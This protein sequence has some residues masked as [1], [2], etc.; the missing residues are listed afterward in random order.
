MDAQETAQSCQ[1]KFYILRWDCSLRSMGL[2]SKRFKMPPLDKDRPNPLLWPW[3]NICLDGA[4]PNTC[5][6]SFMCRV[7]CLSITAIW[8]INHSSR[9]SEQQT[10]KDWPVQ[11]DVVDACGLQCHA[12]GMEQFREISRVQRPFGDVGHTSRSKKVACF[13]GCFA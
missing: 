13:H 2:D 10:I 1:P 8:D 7:L 3:M 6:T 9:N 5:A 4:S 11:V 12:G